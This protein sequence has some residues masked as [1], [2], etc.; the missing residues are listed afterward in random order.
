VNDALRQLFVSGEINRIYDKWFMSPI[1]PEGRNFNLPMSSE[2]Q[3][4]FH[5]P[6]E[7]LQ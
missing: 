4:A 2:L 3:A 6:K 7:Y 1:P 5:D